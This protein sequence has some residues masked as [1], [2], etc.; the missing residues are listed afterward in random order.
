MKITKVKG[1]VQTIVCSDVKEG[2]STLIQSIGL[3][4]LKPNTVMVG[5]PHTRKGINDEDTVEH[6]F[7]G[8]TSNILHKWIVRLQNVL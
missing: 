2:V 4:A 6:D 7:L 5:W 1:F 3:G 8:N